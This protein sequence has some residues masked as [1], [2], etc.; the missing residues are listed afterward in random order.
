[1]YENKKVIGV[2]GG[3]GP[4]AGIDLVRN[5]F[6]NTIAHKDQEHLSVILMS[7][8]SEI[9]DRTEFL[10]GESD[11]NPAIAISKIILKMEKLG[12]DV[13]GIPC[14][15]S[16][17]PPIMNVVTDE[18]IKAGSKVKL[19][20]IVEEVVDFIYRAYPSF[21]KV[22]VLSSTGTYRSG[23]YKECLE[24]RDIE[25]IAPD[26]EI[27]KYF[28]HKS[29]YDEDYGIKALSNPV[30]DK[31]KSDLTFAV[32]HLKGKGAQAVILGCTELSLAISKD[33]FEDLHV[34]DSNKVLARALIREVTLNKLK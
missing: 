9:E 26:E 22:G 23:I 29:I 25:Y 4:Y 10:T 16:H 13:V 11:I 31:A 21:R 14:N 6:D 7:M 30:T 27:Q 3:I 12:A 34:I 19:I 15:T 17:A 33:K 18:L 20:N 28:V 8:P 2:V 1:M 32:N 24:Q 5:I